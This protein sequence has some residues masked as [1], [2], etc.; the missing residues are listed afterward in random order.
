MTFGGMQA[1]L[2][3]SFARTLIAWQK[4]HGRHH[5]PWQNTRDPYRIWLSEIMLQQTQVAAVVPYYERFLARFPTLQALAQAPDDAVMA[6]WS[7]LGYYARARNLHRCAQVICAEYGGQFPQQAATIA[8]LPG[9]GRSTAAAI[10]AFA[11]RER[12]AILDGN[13]K[14]VLCRHFGVE[15]FPG[16]AQV[17]KSLWGLAEQLL[18]DAHIEAYT[19]GLMDLGASLCQ[20]SKPQCTRCP[21]QESCVAYRD[22]RTNAL[23]TP[24]PPRVQVQRYALMLVIQHGAAILLEKRPASGIWGGLWSLPQIDINVAEFSSGIASSKAPQTLKHTLQMCVVTCLQR[25]GIAAQHTQA[26]EELTAFKHT[27]THFRLSVLPIRVYLSKRPS[28][29]GHHSSVGV[30]KPVE[31]NEHRWL[32][33]NAMDQTGLPA[34]VR[35][36]LEPLQA[37]L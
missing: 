24:R 18:P 13:V 6:L 7:G 19:Q 36:L 32:A 2:R 34:P 9:V 29:V 37:S 8:T 10:A 11:F 33:L 27:F 26:I 1:S 15:G 16:Q 22:Q 17:E 28:V 30:K 14:R 25:Y 4:Q 3:T 12:A 35:R 23:P 31:L 20:R 21:L 5:L